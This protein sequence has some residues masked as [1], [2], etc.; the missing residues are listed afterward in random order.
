MLRIGAVRGGYED[1]TRINRG[2]VMEKI[3]ALS[4][5]ITGVAAVIIKIKNIAAWIGAKW[6]KLSPIIIPILVQVEQDA[7]DGKITKE[8]RKNLALKA[9]TL[10]QEK[11]IIKKL[12]WFERKIL[13][14]VIDKLAGK[15]PD[16]TISE[17]AKALL[18][19]AIKKGAQ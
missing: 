14:L 18:D 9:I 19:E 11:G 13:N 1:Y 7:L 5:I 8:E 16:F 3:V 10:A 12:N 2:G 4:T 6:T 15:L 17:Q